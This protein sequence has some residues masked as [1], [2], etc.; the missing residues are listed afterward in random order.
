M[1]LTRE[2]VLKIATLA[3]LRLTEEEV[4]RFTPQL[5]SILSYV[6]VLKELDTSSVKE[7]SQVTGLSSVTRADELGVELCTPDE[8]LATSPLPKDDHQI[9]VKRVI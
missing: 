5:T 8:L 4:E 2:Q 7:T 6:D 9:R 1:Q 3:R